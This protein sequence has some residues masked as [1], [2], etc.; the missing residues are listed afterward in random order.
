MSRQ[1][2][3]D[4]RERFF[5]K[6]NKNGPVQPH[7]S[8][9]DECWEWVASRSS[10]GYGLFKISGY[11]YSSH[12]VAWWLEHGD[13]DDS[14]LVLHKCDNR[15]CVRVSHMFLGSVA[16]NSADCTAK[17]RQ[18]KLRFYG[19]KN[20]N[21][22]LTKTSVLEIMRMKAEKVSNKEIASLY[23]VHPQTIECVGKR[24]W[25]W[26]IRGFGNGKVR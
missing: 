26:V 9:I 15:A 13:F 24:T 2:T 6:V 1:I 23:G 3:R 7:V 11:P 18:S 21:S 4:L 5:S 12:R 14:M 16:D 20:S 10:T 17:N 19:E 8:G 25:L 22:K